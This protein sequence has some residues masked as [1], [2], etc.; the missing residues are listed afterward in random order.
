MI[1]ALSNDDRLPHDRAVW[2]EG[3][4][5]ESVDGFR[6]ICVEYDD[7]LIERTFV[8]KAAWLRVTR[9]RFGWPPA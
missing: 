7:G 1:S 8:E 5:A 6:P 9:W 2:R 4:P 3:P